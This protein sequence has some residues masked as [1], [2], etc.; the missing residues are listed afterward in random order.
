MAY[1]LAIANQKGGVGKTTISMGIAGVL[2][3]TGKRVLL[4]DM[5]QQGNLSSSFI[6]NIHDLPKTIYDLLIDSAEIGDIIYKTKVDNINIL[7]ANVSLSDLDTKLAGD[8]DSQYNLIEAVNEINGA[9]DYIVMDCPPNLGTAT[10]MA[11]VAANGIIV[12]IE[13][14][15]WSV[16]GSSQLTAYVNKVKQRAN[17]DL[18][19]LGFVINKYDPRRTIEKSY[20]EALRESYGDLIFQAE[21]HNN[22][23]Y[24]ECATAKLPISFYMPSSP[25]AEL[26]RQFTL[27]LIKK[28]VKKEIITQPN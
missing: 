9:Y 22:V 11:L 2:A 13:C 7:P 12:P 16:K 23:Q 20:N 19:I 27:E 28:H 6:N 4:I 25:Q 3:E 24:T 21:F 15:E 14:Q 5:D 18:E 10:R 26:F 1:R 17:P 8:Y